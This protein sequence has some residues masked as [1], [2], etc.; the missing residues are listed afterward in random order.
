M[1]FI[2]QLVR[3]RIIPLI[4]KWRLL[5]LIL[6]TIDIFAITSAFQ[7]SYLINYS[8]VSGFFFTESKFLILYIVVLPIW[9]LLLYFINVTEIP[10][11]KR[12]RVLLLEYLQSALA[13]GLF[14][15][16]I[17]FIL[18][19][20]WISRLFLIEF[21]FL[22]FIFLF[23]ARLI[24][25]KIFKSYRAKGFNFKSVVLIS[26]DSSLPFIENL[27]TNKEWGYKILAIFTGSA[28]VKEKY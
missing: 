16:I 23:I 4:K 24:E 12:Y 27:V 5:N 9:L 3:F 1:D 25:Y 2:N 13:I 21:T 17:Y 15:L 11:T 22:G 10:R 19:M 7:L 6:G 8:I 20:T 28:A 26:D 18:K 14:L